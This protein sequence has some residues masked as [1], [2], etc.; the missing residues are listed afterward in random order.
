MSRQVDSSILKL[1]DGLGLS[2]EDHDLCDFTIA[3]QNSV[4]ESQGITP[5][6]PSN[7]KPVLGSNVT[8]VVACVLI[9]DDD[10]VLMMQEAKESCA[11]KWY[12]PAG[13]M[14]K[15]ETIVQA[16]IREV[17]EETGLMVDPKTL[18]V[19]ETAGGMWYRFVLTGEVIGG[20]LKT[21]ASADKESLQA[22]WIGNLQEISL[23]SNDILHLI[24]RAQLHKKSTPGVGWHKNLLPASIPHSKDLL[25]LIVVIKRRSTNRLHVLLSEKT[26]IHFPVCEINPAKSV[27]STLRRFMVEMFGADVG[28][29]RPLGLLNLEHDPAS[30]GCCLTLLVAFRAPLEEVPLIGK[31]AWQEVS[32]D[33]EQQLLSV[34]SSKNSTIELHVV[35]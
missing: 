12:L 3:D 15:G 10:E 7:F 34:T 6:T 13:R 35:R 14:E 8:Y 24:E 23:R 33:V 26:A 4:A 20:E 1:L 31:C 30:D 2:G 18:L 27:H 28:Q 29:H 5:T 16:T 32:K 9:N 17:L 25:R 22:K 19:V 21:P 11:G